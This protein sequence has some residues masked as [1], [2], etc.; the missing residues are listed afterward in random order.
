[1]TSRMEVLELIERTLTE[2][3]GP[4]K[5]TRRPDG[6]IVVAGS[7]E[8]FLVQAI[9]VDPPEGAEA[10]SFGEG[11]VDYIQS[12]KGLAATVKQSGEVGDENGE[13]FYTS[14][15]GDRWLLVKEVGGRPFVR[16]L[17][18]VSSGGTV[19]LIDL[20]SFKV[21]EPDSPQNLALAKLLR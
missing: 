16:H 17:P 3:L 11:L 14:S 13:V 6:V 12:A 15:N 8:A 19:E 20:Q 1:M 4:E 21:R 9:L 10:S 5:I 18:N 7:T 2:R